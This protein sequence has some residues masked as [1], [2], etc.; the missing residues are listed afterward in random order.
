MHI[1]WRTTDAALCAALC[2]LQRDAK[3]QACDTLTRRAQ[4]FAYNKTISGLTRFIQM[5]CTLALQ[6]MPKATEPRPGA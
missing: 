1:G 4:G 6:H 3:D 2:R 5:T